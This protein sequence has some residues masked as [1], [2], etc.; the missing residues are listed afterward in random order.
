M[1]KENYIVLQQRLKIVQ[2]C[3]S[4]MSSITEICNTYGI[5]RKTAHKWIDRFLRFGEAGL[6]ALSNCPHNPHSKY[7]MEQVAKALNL[8][9]KYRNWGPKKIIIKLQELYPDETW[10]SSTRLYEIFKEHNLTKSRRIRHRVPSTSPLEDVTDYNDTWAVDIKGW[11]LT[12]DYSKCEPLTITDTYSRYLIICEHLQRHSADCVWQIFEKAF[13]EYGLPNRVRSDNGPPFGSTGVGRLTMLSVN[14]IKAGVVPEWIRPGH[15]E[16]NGRHERFHLTLQQEIASP[17]DKTLAAQIQTMN[18]FKDTYNFERPH[19]AL[20][21]KTPGSCYRKSPRSWNGLL[22]PP[23]YDT[24]E[25][26]VRKICSN[27]CVWLNGQEHYVGQAVSGEYV[28]LK[29]N[30]NEDVDLHYGP[31]YLGVIN[32]KGFEKPKLPRRRKK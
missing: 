16:E 1:A 6:E 18:E 7:T 29:Y 27:G 30:E 13:R 9:A 12:Q 4:G 21:M 2:A 24:R 3:L 17:P 26:E 15:P 8:K 31:I 5:S 20:N 28:G 11:F 25:F 19:E 32:S 22:R 10:F 23:E 14:L